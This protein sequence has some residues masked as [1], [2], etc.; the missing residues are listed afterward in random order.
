M[1][2]IIQFP[3]RLPAKFGFEPAKKRNADDQHQLNLFSSRLTEI[4]RLPADISPF[5]EALLLDERNDC[6]AEKLY[7]RA[8][9]EG[10]LVADAY[11]N[12]GIIES[13]AGRTTKAFDCFTKSLEHDSR[14]F[15]S[16]YNL[17][18]LYFEGD[19]LRLARMHY[20]FAGEINPT[21]PNLYFN[22]GLVLALLGE[23]QAAIDAFVKY[24]LLAPPEERRN[25]DDLL[26][27]LRRA[28]SATGRNTSA[29]TG[30]RRQEKDL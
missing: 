21:F 23:R 11:C 12:L 15:E 29:P 30:V 28:L 25:A 17:G 14:H 1:G 8:I 6:G 27:G 7:R 18:N 3:A 22:L 10:D 13:E 19:N 26:D 20:E 9:L 24:Q 4:R 2:R 5:E 16:H